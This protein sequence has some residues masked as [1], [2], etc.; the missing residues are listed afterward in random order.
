MKKNAPGS[1]VLVTLL[2]S[3]VTLAGCKTG[4]M[5][6]QNLS[7]TI[8]DFSAKNPAPD[9]SNYSKSLRLSFAGLSDRELCASPDIIDVGGFELRWAQSPVFESESDYEVYKAAYKYK[10]KSDGE[11]C[12]LATSPLS[13]RP[14]FDLY[15]KDAV[16][17]AEQRGF[18]ASDCQE[19][20]DSSQDSDRYERRSSPNKILIKK[21]LL[22]ELQ[23]RRLTANL[24]AKMIGLRAPV[25]LEKRSTESLCKEFEPFITGN[26]SAKLSS[27]Q[28][29]T[30]LKRRKVAVS[31]CIRHAGKSP[32]VPTSKSSLSVLCKFVKDRQ[33]ALELDIRNITKTDCIFIN[34]QEI[35]SNLYLTFTP[36]RGAAGYLTDLD[37]CKFLK[38]KKPPHLKAEVKTRKL[39]CDRLLSLDAYERGVK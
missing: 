39:R 23:K 16:M 9:F 3:V 35:P 22:A 17:A 10:G 19:I 36:A 38:F 11:V 24:C 15:F 12:F 33:A 14:T 6:L 13:S 31:T 2:A 21:T 8:S 5:S 32:P 4:E 26:F 18:S 27:D 28:I 1:S 29:G 37:V 7:T 20:I 25:P 30:E 34:G